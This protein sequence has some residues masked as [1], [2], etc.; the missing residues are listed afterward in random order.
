[1]PT[2]CGDGT[3]NS[4][5]GENCST[6]PQDCACPPD[7]VCQDGVCKTPPPEIT[8]DAGEKTPEEATEQSL[9]PSQGCAGCNA[10]AASSSHPSPLLFLLFLLL[11][12]PPRSRRQA[13]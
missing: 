10:T 7:G 12:L 5:G 8:Q 2:P 11:A 6:C 1:M 3:C 4:N 9:P 13:P